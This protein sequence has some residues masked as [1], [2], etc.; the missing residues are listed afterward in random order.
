LR[1]ALWWLEEGTVVRKRT[2]TTIEV[3]Q[4]VT[5]RR[6]AGAALAWCPACLKEVEMVSLKE[7]AVLTGVSLRDICRRVG[8]DDIHFFET[9]DGGLVCTSSLLNKVSL[10]DG[11]LNSDG[12]NT[13]L[14]P[15]A[16]LSDAADQ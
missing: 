4:I 5:I 13:L 10:G 3:H 8:A 15:A 14:L 7:A 12:A 1:P 9:A 2:V 6:L 11:G 16:D